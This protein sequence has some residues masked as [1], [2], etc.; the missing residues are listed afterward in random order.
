MTTVDTKNTLSLP[1]AV[2][3]SKFQVAGGGSLLHLYAKNPADIAPTYAAIKA[4][5]QDYDVY[6]ANEMPAQWHYNKANDTYHRIG[7]ILLVPR[8]PHVFVLGKYPAQPGQHGFDPF[9]T[10]MHAT[11]YAWGPQLKKKKHIGGFEN[12]HIYPLITRLLGLTYTHTIDG[13]ATVLEGVVR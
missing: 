10:E 8:L 5:A 13:D 7:D 9:L 11:F 3:T 4:A 6:L 1:A 12:V 2:D